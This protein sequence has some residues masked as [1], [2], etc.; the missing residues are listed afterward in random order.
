MVQELIDIYGLD[1]VQAYMGHIQSNA[2]VA[3]RDMLREIGNRT[4]KQTGK[5]VLEAEEFMDDG[6]PIKL[7]VTID[8]NE[9]TAI[10]DFRLVLNSYFNAYLCILMFN[11]ISPLYYPC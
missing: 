6:S 2:E 3:V 11:L 9:G 10:C 5:S 7:K 1:V 8:T 4:L